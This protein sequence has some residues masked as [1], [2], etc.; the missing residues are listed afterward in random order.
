METKTELAA[1]K[2]AAKTYLMWVGAEHYDSITSYATEAVSMGISKR[3]P[4]ADMG[5]VLMEPG[6]L[7]FLAHDEHSYHECPDCVGMIECPECRKRRQEMERIDEL[8]PTK[9]KT[10]A[11]VARVEAKKAKLEAASKACLWCDGEGAYKAGTGG[12]VILKREPGVSVPDFVVT[13]ETEHWDYIRYNYWLHQPKT[14]DVSRVV[15]KAMCET[16]GGTG[17]LPDAKVFGLFIPKALEYIVKPGDDDAAKEL[18]EKGYVM[19]PFAEVEK[20]PKRGCGKRKPGGCYVVTKPG[21]EG[22]AEAEKTVEELLADGTLAEGT[23]VEVNGS[24]IRFLEPVAVDGIKRF[25]GLKRWKPTLAV[26][27]EAEMIV[28]AIDDESEVAS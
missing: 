25:R 27:A 26:G 13:K 15:E 18:A 23:E 14:F 8:E 28:D 5:K 10:A 16:C 2:A 21:A 19:V 24:F 1:A 12:R 17:R 9:G 7:V 6:T 20:E 22:A 11:Y 3:L 4:N